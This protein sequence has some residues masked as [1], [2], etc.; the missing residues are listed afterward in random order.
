ML[1]GVTFL[2]IT[3]IGLYESWGVR[4]DATLLNYFD[5]PELMWASTTFTQALLGLFSIFLIVYGFYKLFSK[6]I[7]KIVLKFVKG[8]FLEA[9]VLLLLVALLIIPIRGGFQDIPIN[10]SNVYF[11][12]NM[13]ANHAAINSV[14]NFTY[15]ISK[16]SEKKNPYKVFDTK[17]ANK[18]ISK[19][20]SSLLQNT[21]ENKILNTENPN[22]ILILWESLTAKFVGS[23]GGEPTVTEN[24][25]RLSKEGI[26]FTNFYG[27]G[28]RTDKGLISI[29]SGY[30]PQTNKSIIKIPSKSRSLPTLTSKMI[31]LGYDTH[32]YY[33]GD[34]NFGNMNT[35]FRNSGV[36][37]FTDRS[38]F[39]KKDWS[40]KWGAYDHVFLDSLALDLKKE[41]KKPFFKIALTLTSHEPFE[42][43]GEYK[44]G[45]N[46]T[47]NK[48]R[49]SHAYTDKSIGKFIEFAKTQPWYKNTLIVI[50]SDHGHWMPKH[51]GYFNSPKK[52]KIPMLWLG[53]AL[54][55]K[56]TI[57]S[58]IS[59]QTDFAYSLLNTLNKPEEAN[60]FKWSKNI[61]NNSEAQ[62]AHY[63]F[64]KGFGII[65]KN[66]VYVYDFVSNKTIISEGESATKLD[67]LGKSITQ[68]A[69]QDFMDK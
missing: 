30:Y 34:L 53:G 47:E 13:F 57:V 48:F 49:S 54:A 4:I 46:S 62:Y 64:N 40:S 27:N 29:L 36:T 39:N 7:H 52:F 16:N 31:K 18:I 35:Y 28:D 33:G 42:F 68:E 14:W 56:D 41:I 26:L 32:F 60:D 15:S 67:S 25:N 11:S 9:I 21:K 6:S 59:S 23:I 19:R 69:Y 55:K 65:D 50:M 10:Q 24:L 12:K 20:N 45:K 8:S 43:P 38:N 66:G 63:I 22:V 37:N 58:T 17:I 3:D 44:F 1:V 61:F 5:N 2:V 51:N